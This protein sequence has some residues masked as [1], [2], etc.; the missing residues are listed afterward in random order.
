MS[1]PAENT[2]S[3]PIPFPSQSD[4]KG[5]STAQGSDKANLDRI[6]AMVERGCPGPA[7]TWPCALEFGHGGEHQRF[8]PKATA[9]DTYMI[10]SLRQVQGD[11]IRLKAEHAALLSACK[12]LLLAF[13]KLPI[14]THADVYE[15]Y[16]L[17]DEV[18]EKVEGR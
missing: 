12:A 14:N 17:A 2:G 4:A 11:V 8:A 10:G 1:T 16:R 6:M 15:A 9:F 13:G 18:V 3:T 7:G 5:H